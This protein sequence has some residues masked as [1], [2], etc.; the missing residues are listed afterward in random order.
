M[1]DFK[2]FT[3]NLKKTSEH[4]D[5]FKR[6]VNDYK[7]YRKNGNRR[8]ILDGDEKEKEE[9]FKIKQ[10][11]FKIQVKEDDKAH[12]YSKKIALLIGSN[13]FQNVDNLK[14]VEGDI[15]LMEIAFKFHGFDV[16]IV[17]DISK[18]SIETSLKNLKDKIDDDSVVVVYMSGHGLVQ[19][20][21]VIK[22]IEE[23]Q[24]VK[25]TENSKIDYQ[26]LYEKL[27]EKIKNDN[28]KEEV[29]T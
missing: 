14:M 28:E 2:K 9:F 12:K 8:F 27:V 13:T 19:E 4:V 29:G 18:K 26:K 21:T 20:K 25:E 24:K 17:K 23:N 11:E 22:E 16:I 7:E 5:S 1:K 3:E 10:E 6:L 15:S